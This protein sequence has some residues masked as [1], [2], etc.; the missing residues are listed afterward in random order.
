[1][2]DLKRL[3]KLLEMPSSA[4]DP[5]RDHELAAM[6]PELLRMALRHDGVDLAKMLAPVLSALSPKPQL[7]PEAAALLERL[8]ALDSYKMHSIYLDELPAANELVK[9][10]LALFPAMEARYAP[11][12]SNL[13]YLNVALWDNEGTLEPLSE[14]EVG[15][16]RVLL[17]HG[18]CQWSESAK[19]LVDSGVIKSPF[20]GVFCFTPAALNNHHRPKPEPEIQ[21]QTRTKYEYRMV[22]RKAGPMVPF[23]EVQSLRYFVHDG[24]L[25][26]KRWSDA[27]TSAL[28]NGGSDDVV[29]NDTSVQPVEVTWEEV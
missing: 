11:S 13:K 14:G 9:A 26:V 21:P 2:L 28:R 12:T 3:Q 15:L 6:V 4:T 17:D 19:R 25:R 1:M 23:R 5:S 29:G 27:S 18:L 20:Y 8:K 24:M 16:V 7:S 22:V 10:G